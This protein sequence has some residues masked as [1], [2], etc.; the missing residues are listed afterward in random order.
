MTLIQ[1][2]CFIALSCSMSFFILECVYLLLAHKAPVKVK[3]NFGWTPLAEAIS[4]GDR[5]ISKLLLM[6][7]IVLFA[8]FVQGRKILHISLSETSRFS[9]FERFSQ[10]WV[11][12]VYLV[13]KPSCICEFIVTSLLK[14]LKEQSREAL[15]ERR[16]QLTTALQ[17]VIYNGNRSKWSPIWSVII[18]VITKS[19]YQLIITVTISEKNIYIQDKHLQ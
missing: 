2:R 12:A 18:Q 9:V 10:N 15:E 7:Q 19:C 17:E 6:I 8:T 4:Y 11:T 1:Q 5:Q 13:L 14:K 3:N 16:P